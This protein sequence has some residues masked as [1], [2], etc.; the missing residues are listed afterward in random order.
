D[1]DNL[2]KASGARG[3]AL[4]RHAVRLSGIESASANIS[5]D[6]DLRSDFSYGAA[7]GGEPG[8]EPPFD[9]GVPE[10]DADGGAVDA[11]EEPG[12]GDAGEGDDAGEGEDGGADGDDAGGSKTCPVGYYQIEDS[13]AFVCAAAN[14]WRARPLTWSAVYR[15]S[16]SLGGF[17]GALDEGGDTGIFLQA[18]EGLDFCERGIEQ[19]GFALVITSKPEDDAPDYCERDTDEPWRLTIEEAYRDR[20]VLAMDETMEGP[21]GG[22]ATLED[23]RRCFSDFSDFQVR[24][25]EAWRVNVGD[26]PYTHRVMTGPDDACEVDGEIDPRWQARTDPAAPYV[27]SYIAFQLRE[28]DDPE[29]PDSKEALNPSIT[30]DVEA[31]PL[32]MQFTS[33][34]RFDTLPIRM[35]FFPET[36]YL[37]VV[38]AA[39]QGVTSITTFPELDVDET[40]H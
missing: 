25:E 23:L 3:V 13:T 9:G 18:P 29:D 8:E 12:G 40:Y 11:G 36:G 5:G 10:P 20:L 27:D 15:G 17:T 1:P 33:G 28:A 14:P 24:F 2:G 30:L 6:E 21:S 19:D 37:F 26:A 7:D 4:Q 38:D 16:L 34:P 35:R 22:P 32:T 39:S 31:A